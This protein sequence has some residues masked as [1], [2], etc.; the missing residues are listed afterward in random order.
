MKPFLCCI[1]VLS[2]TAV[3]SEARATILEN[4][5]PG[6]YLS[7]SVDRKD[8]IRERN[9]DQKPVNTSDAASCPVRAFSMPLAQFQKGLNDILSPQVQSL[10][11]EL[12]SLEQQITQ[13]ETELQSVKNRIAAHPANDDFKRSLTQ[14]LDRIQN[15]Q[16]KAQNRVAEIKGALDGQ[17]FDRLFGK[18]GLARDVAQYE[19]IQGS[20][21]FAEMH[22]IVTAIDDVFR[23]VASHKYGKNSWFDVET[24]HIWWT[25]AKE[26]TWD[27]VHAGTPNGYHQPESS[28][29]YS[30][31]DRLGDALRN[32]ETDFTCVTGGAPTNDGFCRFWGGARIE[33]PSSDW[34][35]ILATPPNVYGST[36]FF[37]PPDYKFDGG[38]RMP[39]YLTIAGLYLTNNTVPT[40]ASPTT[41]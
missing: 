19:I 34:V 29:D 18:A 7:I 25:N 16:T 24:R 38:G 32:G 40:E 8:V 14:D 36:I 1:F 17:N 11:G 13:N 4:L 23:K 21:D 10:K 26:L 2:L 41:K 5:S 27:D 33:E 39:N 6:L 20:S 31:L 9:C 37:D 15:N 35:G 3:L 12:A 22:L 28:D 30:A